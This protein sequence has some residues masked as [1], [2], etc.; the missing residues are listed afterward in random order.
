MLDFETNNPDDSPTNRHIGSYLNDLMKELQA[1]NNIYESNHSV[2]FRNAQNL[3]IREIQRVIGLEV[4]INNF[5]TGTPSTG[6][7]RALAG[8]DTGASPSEFPSIGNLLRDETLLMT[9]SSAIGS[10]HSYLKRRPIFS[11]LTLSL[12]GNG[13]L[14]KPD[15]NGDEL[16]KEGKFQKSDKLFFPQE[17]E[18]NV[19]PI[20]RLI[21]P[22]GMTIRQLEKDLGCKLHIRG[23]G[24]TRDE[25]KE[26]RLR[27]RP[28]WEHLEEPIHVLITVQGDV[29]EDTIQKL[30][31]IKNLLQDFLENNDTELKRSQLMQLAVIEGTLKR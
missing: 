22:R 25:A 9:P 10:A 16:E 23:K 28:G 30:A 21:G 7:K 11:P 18:V 4:P 26:E 14:R 24:C 17:T 15:K 2:K 6:M 13:N 1:M 5:E 31:N 8:R 27:G 3:I 29:E 20:G 12:I 19:N